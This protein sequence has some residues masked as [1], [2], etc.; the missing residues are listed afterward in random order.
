MARYYGPLLLPGREEDWGRFARATHDSYFHGVG[1]SR[2]GPADDSLA[3][4]DPK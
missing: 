1:T 2:M 4:V 3:V